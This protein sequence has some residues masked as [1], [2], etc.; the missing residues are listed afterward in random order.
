LRGAPEGILRG[1]GPLIGIPPRLAERGGAAGHPLH[2]LEAAYAA[3]VTEAGAVA[4]YLPPQ[5]DPAALAAHLDGLLVPGGGD[6]LPAGGAPAGVDF[7]PVAPAQLA[8]DAALLAAALARGIPVLGICYGMQLLAC[9]F[10]ARL[11]HDI[12][13]ELPRAGAHQL[14]EPE[15]RHA[16]AIVPGT[17]LA[18][19]LGGVEPRVNSRHHQAVADPGPSLRVCARAPDGVVEAVE[20]AQHGYCLGVQWHPERMPPPHRR[21]LFGAFVAACRGRPGTPPAA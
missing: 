18:Q 5:S 2:R 7:D 16:L 3:A 14:P 4:V 8:F 12:P 13:S 20:H 21:S 1:V 6:F 17:L 10:G 19:A 9:H 15:G 11:V